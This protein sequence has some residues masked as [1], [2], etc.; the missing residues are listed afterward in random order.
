M[1]TCLSSRSCS[2]CYEMECL[3]HSLHANLWY[4]PVQRATQWTASVHTLHMPMQTRDNVPVQSAM[5]GTASA[6]SLRMCQ[7][8][9]KRFC[10]NC[11]AMDCC[12]TFFAHAQT[13]AKVPVQSANQWI[14]SA[15]TC[16]CQPVIT[17]LFEGGCTQWTGTFFTHVPTLFKVLRNGLLRYILYTCPNLW[18][19][20]DPVQSATQ[21]TMLRSVDVSG[22]CTHGR[23]YPMLT[24]WIYGKS[25]V[26]APRS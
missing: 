13:C 19:S 12:G 21:W 6:Q 18:Y 20:N 5:Q 16:A 23:C 8:L 2:K 7:N 4:I 25:T 11:Y 26:F 17:F 15:H 1:Q 24:S 10:S 14:P 9:W 3:E 22:T